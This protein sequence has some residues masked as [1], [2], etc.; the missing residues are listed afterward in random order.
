MI[1]CSTDTVEEL[2]V[3]A[4]REFAGGCTRITAEGEEVLSFAAAP[5]DDPDGTGAV[6]Y[7]LKVTMKPLDFMLLSGIEG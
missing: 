2:T 1:N 7:T 4:G 6:Q 3:L 5:G